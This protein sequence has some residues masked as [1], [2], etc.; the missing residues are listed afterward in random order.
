MDIAVVKNA[1]G[2][3]DKLL[4]RAKQALQAV[5]S[6]EFIGDSRGYEYPRKP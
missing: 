2:S 4:S 1:V 5:Q 6:E 3:L